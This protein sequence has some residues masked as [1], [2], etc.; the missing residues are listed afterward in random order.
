MADL[1]RGGFAILKVG[2]GLTFVLRQPLYGLDAIA[3]ELFAAQREEPLRSTMERIRV[4]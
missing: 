3:E 2:P 1:V 4:D